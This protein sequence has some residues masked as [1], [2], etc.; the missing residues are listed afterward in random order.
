MKQPLAPNFLLRNAR[1]YRSW[2]QPDL[3]AAVGTTVVNVSRWERGITH[4]GSYFQRKL[5][6]VF[7]LSSAE[8]GLSSILTATEEVEQAP[9][10]DPA[11]PLPLEDFVDRA[12]LLEQVR[13]D[14]LSGKSTTLLA[15]DG[16]PGV[17][18]TTL[19]VT[20][21][22]DLAIR[23]AFHDG[24]LWAG[25][26]PEPNVQGQLARWGSL[27][28]MPTTEM[29]R[30]QGLEAWALALRTAIGQRHFLFLID[31]A[32]RVEDALALRV[33]GLNSAYLLTT[34]KPP[35]A[36][37]F[38]GSNVT[39]VGPLA[40]E[41]A[42]VLLARLAPKALD[43]EPE[44]TRALV[45]RAGGLPLTLRLMGRYLGKEARS[46]P[47]RR[48]RE[49]LVRLNELP[50]R[51]RLTEPQS[52]L[53]ARPSL[54]QGARLSLEGAIS[55]SDLALEDQARAAL[56]ALAL[57]PP[58]PNTFAEDA[59]FVI[60]AC[61]AGTLDAL[62]DAGLLEAQAERF[63]L[64]QAIAD[65][66]Q[67]CPPDA[68]AE[69]RLVSFYAD[70]VEGHAQDYE[71]LERESAN[72]L[73][74]LHIG[75]ERGF[76]R[77][78][79]R[80]TADL[81]PFLDLRGL[82]DLAEVHVQRA[83]SA[84]MKMDDPEL[85]ARALFCLG[86]L[87]ERRGDLAQAEA[88]FQRGL[89]LAHLADKDQL[90]CTFLMD[91]GMLA[92]KRGDFGRAEAYLQ[93]ALP[94]AREGGYLTELSTILSRLGVVAG[95][96]REQYSQAEA[97]FH[98]ALAVAQQA[99]NAERIVIALTHLGTVALKRRAYDQ[100][101]AHLRE[102]LALARQLGHVAH[103]GLL[104]S[105]VATLAGKRGDFAQAEASLQEG[106][107][108]VRPSGQV[109]RISILLTNL[110]AMALKRGAYVQA[111]AY[112]RE[113]LELAQQPGDSVQ[114]CLIL[115]HLGRLAGERGNLS[116]AETFLREGLELAHQ[117]G[118]RESTHLLLLE[119][120]ELQLK[121]GQLDAA[122]HTLQRILEGGQD[123]ELLA[124]SQYGLARI[125]YARGD[126]PAAHEIGETSLSRFSALGHYMAGEIRAWLDML[127]QEEREESHTP[128]NRTPVAWGR[129]NHQ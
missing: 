29:A 7:E 116:G 31:D 40:D 6:E 113:A 100:A 117:R 33:G 71:A 2:T 115:A 66:A 34:R 102:G 58:K 35:V 65:Y 109:E 47:S 106:L 15:L 37:S 30:L 121:L 70:Y 3:A 48:I 59:A 22:Y 124:I 84:C 8:L 45:E 89:A 80:I 23:A 127:P 55:T 81:F 85:Q 107:A 97:Y 12:D 42:L 94:L 4:P 56:R 17:G 112:L 18:K 5:S 101:E 79:V 129:A 52:P 93:E 73:A 77:E 24:V 103:L 126:I 26:G 75:N 99:G 53:E 28:G 20:L 25:L 27:L 43:A 62:V 11:L 104:L 98:D 9:V 10:L 61:P 63:S 105:E 67:L 120:G 83:S 36:I 118:H 21:A 44:L 16:L 68:A 57:F 76:S 13:A 88:H 19:A 64:H 14:L 92:G 86:S 1:L 122:T 87:V 111:E 96:L 74:A 69:A 60:A 39:A 128:G 51:L 125:A 41:D 123:Q 38:A 72:V 54:P 108:L 46:G 95:L 32:W 82:L 114:I 91:L 90:I 50:A 110:G 49:A 78:L 119:W